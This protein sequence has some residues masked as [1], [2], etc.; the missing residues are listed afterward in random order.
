[1]TKIQVMSLAKFMLN[2]RCP[3]CDCD[4]FVVK[5]NTKQ[6]YMLWYCA[7]CEKVLLKELIVKKE[8]KWNEGF[9][10]IINSL[11]A[12]NGKDKFNETKK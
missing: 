10:K 2:K 5:G 8:K 11:R 6:D 3:D 4:A 7:K 12:D 9:L 1:M